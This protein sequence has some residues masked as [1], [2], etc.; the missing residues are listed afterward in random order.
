M[1]EKRLNGQFFT[2]N[3]KYIF[4]GFSKFIKNK[5]ATDPFAGNKDLIFWAKENGVKSI[6][7]FDIDKNYID[8][9]LVYLN[10]SI[11]FPKKY[12][13]VITNPPYLHKNKATR[14]VKEKYFQGNNSLFEDL[15][16]IS[17]NSILDSEEGILIVPLN[18]LSAENSRRIRDIFFNKFQIISLNIFKK[19]VFKDTTY[20]VISFYYKKK[21]G[22]SEENIINATIFP[23]HKKAKLILNKKYNWQ[24][25]GEFF[26][27]IKSFKNLLGIYRLT[28]DNLLNGEQEVR[29]AFNNIKNVKFYG[30]DKSFEKILRKNIIFL[31]A[32]DSKNGKKIQLEDIR[33]YKVHGL[34]GKS[35][36]RNMAH[37]IFK[38]K[39]G[40][41]TQKKLINYFNK[42]LNKTRQ[43][44]F[45]L[46][47][48][49]FR[50]NNRKRIGFNFTYKLLNYIYL[51]KFENDFTRQKSF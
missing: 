7:G 6:K 39:I 24:L 2:T 51:T 30:V 40:L 33:N 29:L 1:T 18:F 46:F 48:T 41:D 35:T 21:E 19:Q 4:S 12:S 8:S 22:S 49:N 38:E 31:R 32:I 47:L 43:N 20:N 5:I 3:S 34:V 17:I 28:E 26:S 14:E 36:S 45:S 11:N 16:Q 42:E 25:G 37:L 23:S 13:F 44:Y 50:D 9:K 15:Y 10:D 27:V